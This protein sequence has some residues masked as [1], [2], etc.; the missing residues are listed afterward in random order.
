VY[1]AFFVIRV[2]AFVA[3]HLVHLPTA[4]TAKDRN[5]AIVMDQETFRKLSTKVSETNLGYSH[6]RFLPFS[7]SPVKYRAAHPAMSVINPPARMSAAA[8]A[9]VS[10]VALRHPAAA[11]PPA[12]A[13]ALP[14]F[15]SL[16]WS[17]I[18]RPS[19]CQDTLLLHAATAVAARPTTSKSLLNFVAASAAISRAVVPA[20]RR[21]ARPFGCTCT[22]KNALTPQASRP[23]IIAR[24]AHLHRAL[25]FALVKAQS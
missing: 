25:A 8:I 21:D 3:F 1:L 2:S 14:A 20:H 4:K 15:I 22:L 6:Q 11:S 23:E 7:E 13:I 12:F 24:D 10:T 9:P 19:F 17:A 18:Y 5:P 16:F